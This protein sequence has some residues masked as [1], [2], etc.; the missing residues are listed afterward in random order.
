MNQIKCNI[1][2]VSLCKIIYFCYVRLE[3]IQGQVE[4]LNEMLEIFYWG[5]DHFGIN[6]FEKV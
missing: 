6:T 5:R 4:S 3:F 1:L 2:F